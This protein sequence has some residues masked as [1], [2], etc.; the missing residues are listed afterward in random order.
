M[1]MSDIRH[2]LVWSTAINYALL[3]IWFG[4][5]AYAH[6]W[7]YQM[8]TRWFKLST[9]IFAAANYAG[10]AIYKLGIILLNLVPLVALYLSS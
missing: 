1:T 2:V 5:F 4:V 8:H 10:M 3:L 6:D 7:L 9:E